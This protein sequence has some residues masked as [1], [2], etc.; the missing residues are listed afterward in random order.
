MPS[1]EEIFP[2]LEEEEY[3]ITS[4]EDSTYNCVAW[5]VGD[6]DRKWWP[7]NHLNSFSYWPDHLPNSEN[8][9]SF[10]EFYRERGYKECDL[11]DKEDGFEKI[12]IF[13]DERGVPTHVARQTDEGVWTSKCDNLQDITHKL[14]AL[15]G[16]EYGKVVCI[17]RRAVH[18]S[19]D[20]T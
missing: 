11:E 9:Y 3:E 12:A 19:A 14:G 15:E 10:K 18:G 7:N 17:M 4:P 20:G 13:A 5:T 16:E 8:I 2:R 6:K 1:L